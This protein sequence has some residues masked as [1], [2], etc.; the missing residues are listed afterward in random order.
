MLHCAYPPLTKTQSTCVANSS[1]EN[2][3]LVDAATILS[4]D[5]VALIAVKDRQ[6]FWTNDALH[7]MLGYESGELVGQSTRVLFVDD[8]SYDTFLNEIRAALK[9]KTAYT[10]VHT[11]KRKDG[12]TG[13]YQINIDRLASQP[14]VFVGS[15]TD[16]TLRHKTQVELEAHRAVRRP[17]FSLQL[18]VAAKRSLPRPYLPKI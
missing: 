13:W 14:E 7:R 11:R 8:G 6:I 16:E 15:F 12:T 18:P 3:F 10:G 4:S 17:A 5:F 2:I 9:E 1:V